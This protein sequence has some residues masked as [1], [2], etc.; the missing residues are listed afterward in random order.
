M[1]LRFETRARQTRLVLRIEAQ[2]RTF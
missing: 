2:F 1:L